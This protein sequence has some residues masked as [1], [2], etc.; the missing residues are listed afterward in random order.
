MDVSKPARTIKKNSTNLHSAKLGRNK[1]LTSNK[2]L[3][4]HFLS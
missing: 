2:K 3:G 4:E 1:I